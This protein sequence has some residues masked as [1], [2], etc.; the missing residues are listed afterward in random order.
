MKFNKLVTTAL[1]GLGLV[2]QAGAANPNQVFVTGS[3]AF[4]SQAFLGIRAL[5]DG[6]NPQQAFRGGSSTTG[7]NAQ[8][9]LFHGSI[10][11]VETYV[12]C[13]WSGSEAG[14]ASVAQ[15]NTHQVFYLKTDGT[16]SFTTNSSPPTSGETNSFA[17]N[18]DI[19]FADTSQSVSLTTT[20]GLVPLGTNGGIIGIVPFVWAKNDNQS[21]QSNEWVHITNIDDA[22]A[23]QMLA[24][25]NPA[26]LLTGNVSDTN[27]NVYCV[28]RNNGSGT[29]VNTLA[30]SRYGIKVNV[31]QFNIGGFPHSNGTSLGLAE[32]ADPN[33]GYDGGGDVEKALGSPAAGNAGS[34]NQTDPFTSGHGWI[35]V[36][37]L[38]MGDAT[39]LLG[40]GGVWLTYNGVPENNQTVEEGQYN[41][42][43]HEWVYGRVGISGF[44]S[45]FGGNLANAVGGL[46]GGSNPAN[47]DT[48]IQL[49]FMHADK[50]SD[51]GDPFHF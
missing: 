21:S 3:T 35:A 49:R 33:D 10:G 41:F 9:M 18:S 15:P 8:Y 28:G 27:M 5:F 50:P 40:D 26:A 23:R 48:G 25:P 19:T 46:I 37:Y 39:T 1:L 29:R 2:S 36:G 17:T 31:D 32:N 45:T 42:W 16:V 51:T 34:C 14:I 38:G 47:S 13:F 12:T 11:T 22:Q 30:A 44:P 7:N 6:G 43:G 20:P 4:R 24:G